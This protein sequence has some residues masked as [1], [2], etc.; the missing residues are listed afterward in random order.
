MKFHF[1]FL[2]LILCVAGRARCAEVAPF[3]GDFESG[4]LS[5]WAG[6]EAAR[7][8]SIQIVTEPTH[9]GNYAARFTVRAGERATAIVPKLSTTTATARAAKSGIAGVF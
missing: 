1:V 3:V 6:R 5:Q 2:G 9:G 4:D 8:D 7:D